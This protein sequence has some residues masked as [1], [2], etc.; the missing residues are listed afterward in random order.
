MLDYINKG[1]IYEANF[2]MEFYAETNINPLDKYFLLNDISKPPFATFLKNNNHFLLS[3]TP[4][5]YLKKEGN[6]IISQPIKGT[7]KRN[8][9]KNEDEISKNILDAIKIKLFGE[10]KVAVFKKYTDN[11]EAYQLYLN[12]RFYYNQYSKEAFLNQLPSNIQKETY[13]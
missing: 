3:A 7:S 12:G 6:K 2:C 11:V 9:D 8:S 5:R 13:V 10:D 1:D 4:E